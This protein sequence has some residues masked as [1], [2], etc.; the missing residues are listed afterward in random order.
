MREG[1]DARL[2]VRRHGVAQQVAA[3]LGAVGMQVQVHKQAVG[4]G[5]Q[6]AEGAA[7]G[8]QDDGRHVGGHVA[9]DGTHGMDGGLHARRGVGVAPVQV[10]APL[11]QPEVAARHAVGVQHGHNLEHEG[12]AQRLGIRVA[13]LQQEGDEAVHHVAGGG[14]AGVHARADEDAGLVAEAVR[15]RL[16]GGAREQAGALRHRLPLRHD[17]VAAGDGEQLHAPA[18]RR[19]HQQLARVVHRLRRRRAGPGASRLI[20]ARRDGADG[21][22]CAVNVVQQALAVSVRKRVVERKVDGQGG[23]EGVGEGDLQVQ[24]GL[25]RK[26]ARLRHTLPRRRRAA[27]ANHRPQVVVIHLGDL[28][29]VGDAHAHLPAGYAAHHREA[30]PHAVLVL[31]MQL[32]AVAGDGHLKHAIRRTPHAPHPPAIKVAREGKPIHARPRRWCGPSARST[33]AA[34]TAAPAAAAAAAGAPQE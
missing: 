5:G 12:G 31:H 18:V 24:V 33:A 9:Q 27:D 14:L 2:L 30:V 6:G 26:V 23:H 16:G 3:R 29:Q 21:G 32:L 20:A 4:G 1:E 17:A 19:R 15:P 22:Q 7:G 11:V 34:A 25:H 8:R 28:V 10:D 13:R